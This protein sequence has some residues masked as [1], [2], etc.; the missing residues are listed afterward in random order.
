MSS[1]STPMI[2]QGNNQILPIPELKPNM[3]EREL[4][5][6]AGRINALVTNDGAAAQQLFRKELSHEQLDSY[7]KL[8]QL[9]K[10][11]KA[12][13]LTELAVKAALNIEK[14]RQDLKQSNKET[15]QKISND[16]KRKEVLDRNLPDLEKERQAMTKQREELENTSQQQKQEVDN[17]T[18]Q[19]AEVEQ[20]ATETERLSRERSDSID[21]LSQRVENLA[22]QRVALS[23]EIRAQEH[24]NAAIKGTVGGLA[25]VGGGVATSTYAAMTEL[26]FV[27]A[28][29]VPSS[30]TLTPVAAA[31]G[32]ALIAV[33]AGALLYGGYRT[34]RYL[35]S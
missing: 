7:S 8:K 35:F 11:A 33:G 34:V 29:G 31:A 15:N 9:N 13:M 17:L 16:G 1:F 5:E 22:Q 2:V 3:T 23:R 20:Q 28:N 19:A 12:F 25:A 27:V 14:Q 18:R 24:K 10:Q 4:D 26:F 6:I 21:T 32:P 30:V